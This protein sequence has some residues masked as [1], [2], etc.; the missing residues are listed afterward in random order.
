LKPGLVAPFGPVVKAFALEEVIVAKA[1]T[2][3]PPMVAPDGKAKVAQ[4]VKS[5]ATFEPIVTPK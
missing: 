4:L 2:A 1:T 5:Q 3:E